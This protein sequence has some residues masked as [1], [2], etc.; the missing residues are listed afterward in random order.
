MSDAAVV[1]AVSGWNPISSEFV[2]LT[3]SP[4]RRGRFMICH[5]VIR[6]AKGV[7]PGTPRPL[8]RISG[9]HLS[10]APQRSVRRDLPARPPVGH[11]SDLVNGGGLRALADLRKAGC[12]KAIG[13]GVN[14]WEVIR[15]ALD[16]I[17]LDCCLL[18]GRYTLLDQSAQ[19]HLMPLCMKQNVAV[20]I[21]GVFNSGILVSGDNK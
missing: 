1:Q 17:D 18:A 19:Q 6:P 7:R 10:L 2:S 16:V 14:E 3:R 5:N 15:D 13:L 9:S 20:I 8:P 11:W 12:T 4:P 21:G